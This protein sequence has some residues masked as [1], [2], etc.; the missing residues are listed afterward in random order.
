[1][2]LNSL[3]SVLQRLGKLQEASNALVKASGIEKHLGNERG[4][5][6]VLNSLGGVLQRMGKFQQAADTLMKASEIE[7]RLG[8]ERGRAIVL[9]SLGGALQRVGKTQEADQAFA[10]CIFLGEKL[11]D[12]LLL[13]KVRTAYGKALVARGDILAGM[14]Q[15]RQGFFLDA[16]SSNERGLAIVTPLLVNILRRQGKSQEADD[17]L[18]RALAI[19]PN[20]D[21]LRRLSTTGHESAEQNPMV[22]VTGRVKRLL[23]PMGRGRYGF[24][25]CDDGEKDVYFA[26]V[27]I[28]VHLFTNLLVG[29]RVEA[30]VITNVRGRQALAIRLVSSN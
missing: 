25:K 17:F 23:E 14:E 2:V 21:V 15:L 28:G 13:A 9:N 22:K 10:S 26:E 30:D 27:R 1:M 5:A 3:G 6:M 18:T 16:Q 11:K 20:E 12:N 8:N 19:A 4:E 29:S 7:E 24:I